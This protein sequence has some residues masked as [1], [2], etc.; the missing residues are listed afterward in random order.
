MQREL[1]SKRASKH[2]GFGTR[3]Y[4][5]WNSM[6]QRCNNANSKAYRNYG[7]R[8]I[9][10][11]PEWDDYSVFRDWAYSSGYDDSAMRGECTLDRVDV[12]GPYSPDN[13][14]WATMRLQSNNK[15]NTPTYELNGETRSLAEWAEITGV[16]YQTLFRRYKSGWSAERALKR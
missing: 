3:L 13:C 8:G 16:K 12:D 7:G 6:R 15:R 14:R 2:N 5:I 9:T 1:M 11:C 10:I 4:S